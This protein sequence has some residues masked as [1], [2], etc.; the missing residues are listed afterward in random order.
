MLLTESE[1]KSAKPQ[2]KEYKLPDI[3]GFF[4]LVK[5]S[6]AKLWRVR[7][8]FQGREALLSLGA[9]PV[10]TL[11]MARDK[12]L[13]VRRTLAGGIDPSAKRKEAKVANLNTFKA[14][15]EEW[16][17]RQ[18]QTLAENTV[19]TAHSRLKHR[20]Y[21]A[22][23]NRP[24]ASIQPRDLL[25]ILQRVEANGNRETAHRLS[26]LYSMVERYARQ[27][28][29]LSRCIAAD[30]RGALMPVVPQHHAGI[31]D[32]DEFGALLRS[33]DG[34]DGFISTAYALRLSALLFPRPGELR[35]ARWSEFSLDGREPTWKIPAERMKMKL[36]HWVPLNKQA[37]QALREL[38]AQ[39]GNGEYCFP[40]LRG[41]S[42]KPISNN[43]LG[44]ALNAL[45]YS[46]DVHVPHG[47]RTSA[48]TMLNE[49]G[50]DPDVIELQLSH[51]P[52][53][54]IRAA[55]NRAEKMPARRQMMQTW[56]DMC[57]TMRAGKPEPKAK[58][59][60][61]AKARSLSPPASTA[62]I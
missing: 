38:K 21:P 8:M 51:K 49:R 10:T 44:A 3:K 47:F 22:F 11:K 41:G 35:G 43:A 40:G 12:H 48:S 46:H 1:I 34:Y 31:I 56:A 27:T 20:L 57:D 59:R 60:A 52:H 55:Y 23:G 36:E 17:E 5:P 4:L 19:A 24:I 30:L 32:P 13:E 53:D 33:I 7:Y 42:D 54:K 62:N 14:I 28:S 9:Y 39:N 37:V 58:R 16:L 29:R 18:A 2:A 6:G 61:T 25:V 50:S 15:A 26:I 45:G